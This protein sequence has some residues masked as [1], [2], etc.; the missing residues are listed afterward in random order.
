MQHCN[1]SSSNLFGANLYN[2]RIQFSNLTNI[3]WSKLRFIRY[4]R[5]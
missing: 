4:N 5:K 2:S 1:L 3:V